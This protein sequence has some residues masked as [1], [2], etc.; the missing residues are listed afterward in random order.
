MKRRSNSTAVYDCESASDSLSLARCIGRREHYNVQIKK[1]P[2]GGNVSSR[3]DNRIVFGGE[4]LMLSGGR[5][6]D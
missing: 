1:P 4:L 5:I 3:I 6:N 2:F